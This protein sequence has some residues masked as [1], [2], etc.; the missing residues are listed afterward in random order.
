MIKK[1]Q[2]NQDKIIEH[3]CKKYDAVVLSKEQMTKELGIHKSTMDKFIAKGYGIPPYKKLGSAK[4]SKIVFNIVD[5]A[6]F[7]DETIVTN[8]I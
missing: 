7:L 8:D 5:V 4:N 6:K 3:L 1:D 2:S